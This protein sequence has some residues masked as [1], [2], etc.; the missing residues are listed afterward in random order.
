MNITA[1][2]LKKNYNLD[3]LAASDPITPKITFLEY[4]ANNRNCARNTKTVAKK[5]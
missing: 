4:V 1:E 5:K 2:M 3:R